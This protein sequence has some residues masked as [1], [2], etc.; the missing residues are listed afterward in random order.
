M[1]KKQNNNEVQMSIFDI[2]LPP[3]NTETVKEVVTKDIQKRQEAPKE[4]KK[5][6]A[7]EKKRREKI[8]NVK[9]V[10]TVDGMLKKLDKAVYK[11]G[12]HEFLSDLFECGAIAISNKFD[13]RQAEKREERYLQIIN[14]YDKSTQGLITE[15][16]SD[17]F[18]LLT[19]QLDGTARFNDYLGE[20]YMRSETSNKHSGQFFTPYNV[21]R[22]CAEISID[23]EK[24]MRCMEQNEVLTLNEPACG[25]S[26]M[27]IAA[28]DVLYNQCD[29]NISHNLFVE[30]SDIDSRCVHMSYLQLA[31]TGIPAVIYRRNTLSM[32]TWERWETPALI[33]QWMRFRKYAER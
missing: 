25:S 14:K 33:M 29:F 32:E 21:S 19:S 31:F 1:A 11:V 8:L 4:A 30:C 7:E 20:L 3:N 26:G 27:I 9:S 2:E 15:L 16:F 13:M 10:P 5:A 28:A 23:K 24:A 17:I 12:A 18:V 22:A 6:I